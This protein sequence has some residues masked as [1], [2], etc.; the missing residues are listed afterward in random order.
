MRGAAREGRSGACSPARRRR[1]ITRAVDD[2]ACISR[3]RARGGSDV[4]RQRRRGTMRQ[5]QPI[6]VEVAAAVAVVAAVACF[7]CAGAAAAA[8]PV[9]G[10]PPTLTPVTVNDGPGDQNDPHVS[11]DWAA[12]SSD[13]AIRYYD[14]ANDVDAEIP[15]GTS[16]R[17]LLPDVSGSRIVFSRVIPAVRTAVMVF[18]AATAAPP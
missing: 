2:D 17:D 8:P 18:D 4:A 5:Q 3:V 1:T 6:E 13:L 10:P 16:A 15:M 9:M 7:T 11:G 12:Y 14:F